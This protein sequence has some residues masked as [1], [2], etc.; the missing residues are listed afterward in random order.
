LT[1]LLPINTTKMSGMHT[2]NQITVNYC[3]YTTIKS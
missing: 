2:S 1:S 3:T